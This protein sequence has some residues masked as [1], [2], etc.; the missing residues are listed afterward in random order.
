VLPSNR[1]LRCALGLTHMILNLEPIANR[2]H[3]RLRDSLMNLQRSATSCSSFQ[4]YA[5]S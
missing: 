4:A 3:K 1:A 2:F 5:G